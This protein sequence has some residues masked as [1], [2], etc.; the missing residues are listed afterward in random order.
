MIY[1]ERNHFS[2]DEIV[3][4]SDNELIETPATRR[5]MVIDLLKLGLLSDENGK[6]SNRMRVKVLDAFGFGNWENSRDID[7]LHIK[8]AQ[9]ENLGGVGEILPPLEIDDHDIHIAEHTKHI[10]AQEIEEKG[11][12]D[13]RLIEHIKL[14]KGLNGIVQTASLTGEN[15]E[16]LG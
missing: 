6:L 9:K 16:N 10:L 4:D 8:K 5:G 3:L 11:V 2:H 7:E 14:H 12:V 15:Y 1:F 13:F